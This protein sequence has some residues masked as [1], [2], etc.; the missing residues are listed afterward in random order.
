[1]KSRMLLVVLASLFA[2]VSFS[3]KSDTLYAH[4]NFTATTID[5]TT[6]KES[7]TALFKYYFQN[8]GNI[9][10]TIRYVNSLCD[11]IVPSWSKEKIMPGGWGF[12]TC[13]YNPQGHLGNFSKQVLV[14]SNARNGNIIL[15]IKGY[16]IK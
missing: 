8:T 14:I 3:Q 6:I 2:N 9:P 1:M 11:C 4:I 10:L 13:I 16:I 5:T 12:V 7:T 15:N